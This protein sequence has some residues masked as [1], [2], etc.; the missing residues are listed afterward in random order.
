MRFFSYKDRPVH[1]GPYPLERLKRTSGLPDL[2]AVPPMVPVSFVRQEDPLSLVNAMRD[3]QAM[4]DAIRD[5]LVKKER[6]VIP[7]DLEERAAHLKAFGY[8]CDASQV[9]ICRLTPDM[10]LEEPLVNPGV[11]KLAEDLKTRQ[12]ETL[13]SGIDV[14]MAELRETM[15]APPRDISHHTHALVFLYVLV[16]NFPTF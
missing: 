9:G 13:A 7:D 12:T 15:E 16:Q 8:Y 14:V 6:A 10:F 1:L 3:Y 5:G 11:D 4:M 2:S